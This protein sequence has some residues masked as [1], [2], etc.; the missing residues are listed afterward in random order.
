[1]IFQSE[2]IHYNDLY[3]IENPGDGFK[4]GSVD[5]IKKI[6]PVSFQYN[7]KSK[8]GN[9]WLSHIFYTMG[10]SFEQ[11]IQEEVLTTFSGQNI[12]ITWAIPESNRKKFY[13]QK[14]SIKSII[15]NLSEDTFKYYDFECFA[16]N[17]YVVNKNY[18]GS[19]YH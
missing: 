13:I 4:P 5:T 3:N 2:S 8:S 14:W 1:M 17:D 7:K 18:T 15:P 6:W 12:F 11:R 16:Y 9:I 10:V 19:W